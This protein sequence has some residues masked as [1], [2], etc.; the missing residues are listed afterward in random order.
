MTALPQP[1]NDG[2]QPIAVSYCERDGI[3]GI[4]FWVRTRPGTDM[5]PI[6]LNSDHALVLER[7]LREAVGGA[8]DPLVVNAG[9]WPR[10]EVGYDAKVSAVAVYLQPRPDGPRAP[11]LLVDG[12]AYGLADSTHRI[13]SERDDLRRQIYEREA[14]PDDFAP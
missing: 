2:S 13:I 3:D 6:F 4:A 5:T 9:D 1:P 12:A 8:T 7:G 11:F 14:D 10:L